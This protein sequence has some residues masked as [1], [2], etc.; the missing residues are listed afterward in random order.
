MLRLEQFRDPSG[1]FRLPLGKVVEAPAQ[2]SSGDALVLL[3]PQSAPRG[4]TP[5]NNAFKAMH[6]GYDHLYLYPYCPGAEVCMQGFD[7]DITVT[8]GS[9]VRPRA[10]V[11]KLA[12]TPRSPI[13]YPQ[14]QMPPAPPSGA[15][16]LTTADMYARAF[17]VPLDLQP[18][19]LVWAVLVD[20]PLQPEQDPALHV[21]AAFAVD[22]CTDWRWFTGET[23]T[24]PAGWESIVDLS[25]Q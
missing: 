25:S 4:F 6:L 11:I 12:S 13:S 22:A 14:G 16:K 8:D 9:Q 3:T 19:T 5:V 1:S 2:C 17:N 18:Q 20:E 21:W 15:T 24:I 10:D 7:A 23:H